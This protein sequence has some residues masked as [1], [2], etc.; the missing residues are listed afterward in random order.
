M[1]ELCAARRLAL[2]PAQSLGGGKQQAR[3]T[4]RRSC[5]GEKVPAEARP[6]Q[7]LSTAGTESKGWLWPPLRRFK[8]HQHP[9]AS[10]MQHEFCTGACCG[11]NAP[12]GGFPYHQK[13][14]RDDEWAQLLGPKD[15]GASTTAPESF[16][17]SSYLLREAGLEQQ[18]AQPSAGSCTQRIIE[19]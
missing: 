4:W 5:S 3:R 6:A 14:I 7:L 18:Q 1:P 19:S 17:V 15:T 11:V 10:S 8:G 13:V 16:T 9:P 2:E 12:H